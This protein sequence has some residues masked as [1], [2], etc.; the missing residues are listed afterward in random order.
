VPRRKPKK[1]SSKEGDQ[2]DKTVPNGNPKNPSK[3]A[4]EGDQSV[5]PKCGSIYEESDDSCMY[6]VMV[7]MPGIRSVHL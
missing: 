1:S 2:E 4:A 6:V 3:A 5:C 7:V